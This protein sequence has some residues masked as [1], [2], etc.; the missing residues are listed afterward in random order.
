MMPPCP[1][2]DAIV[3]GGGPAGL[4]A[5]L[6]LGRCRRKVALFDE[7][8][9]RN[10]M[11]P[12]VHG[13]LGAR[14]LSPHQLLAVGRAQ[15]AEYSDVLLY[16]QRVVEVTHQGGLFR[17]FL[18]DRSEFQARSM[19]VATGLVDRLPDIPGLAPLYGKGVYPCPYCDGWENQNRPIAAL[20]SGKEA[21]DLALELKLWSKHVSLF[22]VDPPPD[23]ELL[24]QLC[25]EGIAVY[26]ADPVRLLD[27][28]GTLSIAELADGTTVPCEALFLVACQVQ[29]HHFMEKMGCR[30]SECGQVES[31]DQGRTN[32]PG[33]FVAGNAK[34]GLQLAIV[35]AADGA[36]CAA[37]AND[38]LLQQDLEQGSNNLDN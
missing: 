22:L 23:R 21:A 15:I 5:G 26:R 30:L 38:W 3:I 7:G 18:E 16:R 14:N 13:F 4:S 32:M 9:P 17:A 10:E 20:G 2:F 37:A 1:T 6:L 11:S 36:K 34:Q 12:T 28:N 24:E 33:L 31:D 8:R 19:I 27:Q 29:H 35:A 25:N